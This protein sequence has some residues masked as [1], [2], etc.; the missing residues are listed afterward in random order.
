MVLLLCGNF[1]GSVKM[2][3]NCQVTNYL[4]SFFAKVIELLGGVK[5]LR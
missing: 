5:K 2:F 1:E 3:S 4:I